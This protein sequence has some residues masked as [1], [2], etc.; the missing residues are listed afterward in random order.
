MDP[1][2]QRRIQ[3][4]GWDLAVGAY[5]A[6]WQAPLAPAQAK[7]L[8][9]ASLAPGERVLDV[10]AGTGSVTFA[11]ARFVGDD[12]FAVG[13]DIS[14]L[15]VETA[16][17]RADVRGIGNVR[18]ERMDAARLK[19]PDAE[20]DAALCAMG[21]MYATDPVQA[22]REMRR[23]LRPRGRIA[24]SAWGEPSRCGLDAAFAT[25]REALRSDDLPGFIGLGKGEDLVLACREAQFE[26]VESFRVE[27]TID[28]AGDDE[29]CDAAFRG[30]AIALAWS[31]QDDAE[32]ARIRA[33]FLEAIGP[34]RRGRGYEIPA[35]FVIAGARVPGQAHS[36]SHHHEK[37]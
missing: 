3:R 35:E 7:L 10:A 2:R 22:L 11:A 9:L 5:E 13:V 36:H 4:Y 6:F 24:V 15:M 25:V 34:W 26:G 29:A 14:G 31:R 20:F 8:E 28:F 33:R 21:L 27:T 12:G 18:F 1:R 30:G 32:R 17:R 19:L 37:E 16:R 23:V